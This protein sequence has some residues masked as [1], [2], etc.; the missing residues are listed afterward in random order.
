VGARKRRTGTKVKARGNRHV[1]GATPDS[2]LEK[3]GRPRIPTRNLGPPG[4]SGEKAKAQ[5]LE[6]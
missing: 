5:G 4:E 1:I 6:I 3:K 2:L